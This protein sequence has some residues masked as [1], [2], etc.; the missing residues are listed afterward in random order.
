MSRRHLRVVNCVIELLARMHGC[1]R[2]VI[3]GLCEVAEAG[4]TS[5]D[6]MKRDIVIIS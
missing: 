2:Q 5:R 3:V 4:M 1:S 6:N